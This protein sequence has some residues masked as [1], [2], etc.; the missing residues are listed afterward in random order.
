MYRLI[1][2][3]DEILENNQVKKLADQYSVNFIK[4]IINTRL[5]GI[6]NM[7]R[8]NK[9]EDEIKAEIRNLEVDIVNDCNNYLAPRLRRLVNG[10]G[11]VIHT[12]LG[13]SVISERMA[14]SLVDILTH[15][16]NLEYD[17][18]TG[19]R[20]LRY[21]NIEELITNILSLIHI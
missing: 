15:Y 1:P 18:H 9:N 7:I 14:K 20:G 16:S 2:K 10:T 3:M 5:D 13:R 8:D 6:R 4:S 17:I 21:T 11:T 19:K 12:N